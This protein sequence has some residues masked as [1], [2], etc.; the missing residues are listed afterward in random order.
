MKVSPFVVWFIWRRYLYID[1]I[2]SV[3]CEWICM[4]STG[5]M[6]LTVYTDVLGK[7]L[8]LMPLCVCVTHSLSDNQKTVGSGGSNCILQSFVFCSH[9]QLI[10]K[11]IK[12]KRMRWVG[13]CSIH[14]GDNEFLRNFGWQ[15]TGKEITWSLTCRREENIK[16]DHKE[17]FSTFGLIHLAKDM[18]QW[19][20]LANTVMNL[21]FH[22]LRKVS[23]QTMPFLGCNERLLYLEMRQRDLLLSLLDVNLTVCLSRQCPFDMICI[24][25]CNIDWITVQVLSVSTLR[26]R[27]SSSEYI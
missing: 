25:C 19:Q 16:V 24:L 1:N 23:W 21:V 14:D 18:V 12:P 15:T 11:I 9:Y 4:R 6:I 26:D 7:I 3:E 8:V 27:K 17:L 20:H 10:I 13:K 22:T 2:S 5:G